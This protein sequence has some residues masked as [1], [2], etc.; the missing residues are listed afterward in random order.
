MRFSS[1]DI[2][3]PNL[4]HHTSPRTSA[5]RHQHRRLSHIQMGLVQESHPAL[6]WLYQR[7]A[8][9]WV[10]IVGVPVDLENNHGSELSSCLRALPLL[11]HVSGTSIDEVRMIR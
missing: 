10:P 4:E 9:R 5:H 2:G 6:P 1:P 7:Y 3:Y 8:L 11:I